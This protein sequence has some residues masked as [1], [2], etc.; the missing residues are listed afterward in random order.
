M[1]TPHMAT[2][3][4]LTMTTAVSLDLKILKLRLLNLLEL[5]SL[6]LSVSLELVERSPSH[7]TLKTELPRKDNIMKL[8]KENFCMKTRKQP[9]LSALPSPMRRATR[10]VSSCMWRSENQDISLRAKKERVLT[11]P[12]LML[13]TLKNLPKRK[14]SL[15]WED[16]AWEPIPESRSESESP[17][18][19][20]ILLTK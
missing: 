8:K 20:R 4:I 6:R 2:I 5:M 15:C 19:S 18:S 16:L 1:G 11:I 14:R 17:R 3:M 12:N 13:R 7:S 10:R 9:K